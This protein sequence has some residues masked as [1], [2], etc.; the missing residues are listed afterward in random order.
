MEGLMLRYQICTEIMPTPRVPMPAGYYRS[1]RG[2]G[3]W[4]STVCLLVACCCLRFDC[5]TV[6]PVSPLPFKKYK[7]PGTR[8]RHSAR[9]SRV[10]KTTLTR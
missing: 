2:P 7:V 10:C 5:F 6:K 4:S 9:T 3:G 1:A 8:W